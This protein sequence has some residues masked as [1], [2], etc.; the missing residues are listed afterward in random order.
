[1]IKVEFSDMNHLSFDIGGDFIFRSAGR[2]IS[3]SPSVHPRRK[4]D[5]AVLL[6]GYSGECGI[7]QLEQEYV[8]SKGCF[9]LLFPGYEHYGTFASNAGQSHFWC[10]FSLPEQFYITDNASHSSDNGILTLP[11]FGKT[12]DYEKLFVL[13]GQLI[14]ESERISDDGIKSAICDSYVKILLC[15]L[16][17]FCRE[18]K[19]IIR[20]RSETEK[21]KE[22]LRC[23]A[24]SGIS[25]GDAAK[26]LGYNAD[27]LCRLI[28]RD[29]GMT[30]SAYL[31][32][33]RL[34]EAKN[35]LLNSDMKV[36]N[37]AYACGFSDEKYFMKLFSKCENVTPTQYREA[38]F[39]VHFNY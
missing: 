34:N 1:M 26:A 4:L 33:L 2:F 18:R 16:A 10:H 37:V 31:N 24:C 13:F 30:L 21:I 35:L 12:N 38:H 5:T 3:K 11:E 6:L 28:K 20:G 36:A 9:M 7:S 14:D 23:N 17:D 22:Y 27:H 25:A 39:R 15:S 8:L 19:D 29:S 32:K